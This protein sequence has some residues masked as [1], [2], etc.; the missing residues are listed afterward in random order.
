MES[1]ATSRSKI[2]LVDLEEVSPDKIA[3]WTAAP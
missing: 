3:A 2:S 1:G